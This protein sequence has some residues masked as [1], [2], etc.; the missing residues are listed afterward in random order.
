M[1]RAGDGRYYKRS[2][3][4]FSRMEHYDLADMF[5]RRQ[6]PRLHFSAEA[7]PAEGDIEKITL[8][9]QN[10]G[11]A[12]AR[13]IGLFQ[14]TVKRTAEISFL[15]RRNEARFLQSSKRRQA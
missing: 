10:D 9:L 15:E 2:G 1:A 12:L 8:F 14:R 13:D 11:R 5:G 3:D 4:S 6:K 7:E